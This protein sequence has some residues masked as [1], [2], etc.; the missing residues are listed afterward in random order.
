MNGDNNVVPLST[1]GRSGSGGG[2][3]GERLARIEAQ[4]EHMAT[5]EDLAEV[6][7]L[8]ERKE[9]SMLCW[10][11]GLLSVAAISVVVAMLRL[12]M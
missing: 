12:F 2:D 9:A 10:L 3:Y 7:A 4:L 5:R 11:L 8:I 6:K 1:P